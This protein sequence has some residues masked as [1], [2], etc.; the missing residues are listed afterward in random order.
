MNNLIRE[1]KNRITIPEYFE[2]YINSKINLIDTPKICCPFHNESTP[3]FS[4]S[5]EKDVWRCFGSCKTGGDV[6]AMHQRNYRLTTRKEAVHSLARLLGIDTKQISLEVV[7]GK[8][9]EEMCSFYIAL[10][11]ANALCKNVD[12]YIEL[13]YIMSMHNDELSMTHALEEFI[14][15]RYS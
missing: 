7:T 10:N 11:R 9:K 5:E 4:Y 13:D 12:D 14:N 2:K 1:I 6:I 3:S 8:V 15:A